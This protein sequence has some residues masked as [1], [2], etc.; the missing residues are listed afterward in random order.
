V[1]V[2][3]NL[4]ADDPQHRQLADRELAGQRGRH[5]ARGGEV[6]SPSNR[7]RALRRSLGPSGW[8]D[9]GLAKR[10]T[11]WLELAAY[12]APAGVQALG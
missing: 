1:A 10:N 4:I 8:E 6:P 12:N 5:R 3:A 7:D 2:L 11:D 9:R